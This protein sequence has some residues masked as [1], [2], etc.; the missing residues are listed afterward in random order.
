M[1]IPHY[2]VAASLVGIISQ[3]LVRVICATCKQSYKPTAAELE[4][5]GLKD[6]DE[7]IYYKGFGCVTCNQTGYKGRMAVHEILVADHTFRDL[8]HNNAS[9]GEIRNYAISQGMVLLRDSALVL[10]RDGTTTLEELISI[11]HGT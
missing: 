11:T 8:V 10:V 5:A 9:P 2:M 4:L 6:D 3:R 1:G 7:H